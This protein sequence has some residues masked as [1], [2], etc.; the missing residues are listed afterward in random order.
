[1]G[2]RYTWLEPCLACGYKMECY[3]GESCGATD[4]KC[5]SCGKKYKIIM[6]FK[7]V[8]IKSAK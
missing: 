6:D 4:V 8:E 7:L 5:D 2:D 3:Y 1:M